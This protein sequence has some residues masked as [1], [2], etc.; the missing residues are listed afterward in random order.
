MDLIKPFF[1]ASEMSS[2]RASSLHAVDVMVGRKIRSIRRE[3]RL[4]LE[5]LADMIGVTKTKLRQFESGANVIPASQFYRI[6]QALE[7]EV[8]VLF[9]ELPPPVR[10]G[11]SKDAMDLD[12]AIRAA[13]SEEA[14]LLDLVLCLPPVL[15]Q[16]AINLVEALAASLQPAPPNAPVPT[17]PFKGKLALV[18]PSTDEP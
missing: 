9:A 17:G 8:A 3:R 15:R 18:K 10:R 1:Q 2:T 16:A 5:T 7:V 4:S 13:G 11:L 6:A 12:R 14:L